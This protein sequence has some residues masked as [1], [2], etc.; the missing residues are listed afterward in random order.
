MFSFVSLYVEVMP[1]QRGPDRMAV[2]PG[3]GG[4]GAGSLALRH[5]GQ[6]SQG[7]ALGIGMVNFCPRKISRENHRKHHGTWETTW[8]K[9]G[10]MMENY[11]FCPTWH[12]Q[13]VCEL[14]NHQL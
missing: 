13:T 10:K 3:S 7:T 12:S 6:R 14:E 11:D 4:V 5:R 1:L 9:L 2:A 8:K